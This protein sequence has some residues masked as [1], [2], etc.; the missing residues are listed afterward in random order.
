M[1]HHIQRGARAAV[2][3]AFAAAAVLGSTDAFAAE[4]QVWWF[5]N[6]NIAEFEEG[7]VSVGSDKLEVPA[8]ACGLRFYDPSYYQ[9]LD[10][11]T[12]PMGNGDFWK[13]VHVWIPKPGCPHSEPF[14][15]YQD[16][17]ASFPHPPGAMYMEITTNYGVSWID[18]NGQ[19]LSCDCVPI[20]GWH[21]AASH[22]N[23][24]AVLVSPF[25]AAMD[26]LLAPH[27][28]PF[29][30]NAIVTL[31]KMLGDVGDRLGPRV[32]ARRRHYLGEFEASVWSLEEA[33][34]RRLFDAGQASSDCQ[35]L[36]GER[37]YV[38]AFVACAVA[39]ET[40]DHAGSLLRTAEIFIGL[41]PR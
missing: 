30:F 5:D 16:G 10:S 27:R 37:R 19:H 33:A 35:R 24:P 23:E 26:G 9:W 11:Y 28:Q 25:A 12:A 13:D 4:Y 6:I 7:D 34:R 41:P 1:T 32:D 20:N 38:E 3:I 39:R 14:V 18:A 15:E 29:V 2:T 21:Y 17:S 40:V 8:S 22:V 36:A 31:N